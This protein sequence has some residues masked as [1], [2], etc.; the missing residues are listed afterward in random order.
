MIPTLTIVKDNKT[1]AER[2]FQYI[3]SLEVDGLHPPKI[4]FKRCTIIV[5]TDENASSPS[6]EPHYP[7]TGDLLFSGNGIDSIE[8]VLNNLSANK[9]PGPDN[10]PN[11]ILKL[12]SS[13]IT[14][15][16]QVILHKASMIIHFLLTGY[17]LTLY[18]FIGRVAE[19]SI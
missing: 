13:M 12:C 7:Q 9:S 5:F 3:T 18:Q 15:I 19:I 17:Q 8:N 11:F 2:L 16:L 4:K 14:P 1:Y 10:I 6:L